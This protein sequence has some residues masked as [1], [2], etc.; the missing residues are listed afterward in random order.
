M[1]WSQS[2][3]P[4]VTADFSDLTLVNFFQQLEEKTG[5]VFYYAT[6]D[7]P[8]LR[9]QFSVERQPLSVVLQ[10]AFTGT[11]LKYAMDNEGHVFITKNISIVTT[12]PAAYYKVK[13]NVTKDTSMVTVMERQEKVAQ[14]SSENKLYEIGN[15]TNRKVGNAI[16]NGYIKNANTGEPLVNASI[17]VDNGQKG[18][19]ADQYG[20]YSLTLPPGRYSFHIQGPGVSDA[21]YQVAV[22]NDGQLDIALREQVGILKEVVV[23]SQKVANIKRVAMGVERLTIATIKQVPTVFGEADV[24]RVVLTL[25][26]VK[27]VGEVS[28]GFNVRGGSTDQNLILL[29]DA[30]IYNPSHFFG[31]FSAFNPEIIKDLELYKSSIPAKFGGRLSSVLDISTREGNKKN[32]TG[33]AGLGL[34]TSRFNIEGPLV[35]DRTSFIFGA[36]TTYANWLLKLLPDEYKNSRAHFNDFNLGVSHKMN[37]SNDLYLSAYTSDDGFNLASDTAYGYDNKNFSLKWKHIFSNKLNGSLMVGYDGYKY[38]VQS[39]VNPV[40]AYKLAF[41]IQQLNLKTDLNYFINSAHTLNFG[42]NA[43]HYKLKPG[44]FTPVGKSSLVQTKII[45]DE[46]GLETAAYVSDRFTVSDKFSIEGGL[47]FSVFNYL[48]PQDINVYAPGLPKEEANKIETRHHDG[49]IIK[50]YFGPEYRASLRYAFTESFSIKAGY[51]SLRQYVHML[52]NTTTVAPTDIWKLSDPNIQPQTGQQVSLGFYKNLK[53]NTIETSMELY[54]K[55]MNDYLDYKPGA[56]L[57]LNEA[58]ETDVI[59]T[60]GKAYGVELMV[61]KPGGKLNGWITYTYS[62]TLLQVDDPALKALINKGDFYPANYDKPHDATM[63][64]NFRINHRFSLSLN[65][66]YST[67]RPITLPIAR[68]YYMG[69]QRVLYSDRNQY[70][71]PDYFRMDFSMNIQGNHKVNQKTHNSWTIGVYNLTGRKNPFSVYFVSTNGVVHGNKMSIFGSM[72]PFVNYNIKF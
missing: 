4:E 59:E 64:G 43:V 44:S 57:V 37:A 47:R 7:L 50:T 45:A 68:Y 36:R 35:K 41:G 6:A 19:S 34:I 54:Y 1:A 25:P 70:R 42:L 56:Q 10:K 32:I 40:N 71:I 5:K 13:P 17:F 52:S 3:D 49:G 39:E 46:Q 22:Y 61:K 20:Y 69:S 29:N 23:S 12:L 2:K 11:D 48:G 9:I 55:S 31:M 16:I 24:L 62:R 66:N 38:H 30:T 72:I 53:S 14:T 18:I 65:V 67:G 26:G 58:I 15:Q 21:T 28:T 8:A 33:S 27:T 63:V 51:N 60:K